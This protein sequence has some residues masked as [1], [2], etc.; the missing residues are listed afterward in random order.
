MKGLA[1]SMTAVGTAMSVY[2]IERAASYV[3]ELG[4]MGAASLRLKTSF[5]Q[6]AKS[7][8]S[9]SEAILSALKTASQGTISETDLI[10]G[11]NRAMMLGLSSNATELAQ[12]MEVA[13][14]RARAMGITTTQ[15]WD[16]IVTGIG[17]KSPLILDNL[18]IVGLKMDDTTSKAEIMSQVIV[19]GQKQIAEAGG[20]TVD[21]AAQ[22]EQL[23]AKIAALNTRWAELVAVPATTKTVDFIINGLEGWEKAVTAVQAMKDLTGGIGG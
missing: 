22:F 16:N 19:E 13:A 9:N 5:D 10:L 7:H 20:L 4:R 11:A 23:D 18:G 3:M 6:L 21:A 12:L 8:Q 14:F 17:R 2:G 15:A 1:S